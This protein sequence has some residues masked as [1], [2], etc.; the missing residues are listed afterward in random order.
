MELFCYFVELDCGE[1]TKEICEQLVLADPE[2]NISGNRPKDEQIINND[3]LVSGL[4][5]RSPDLFELLLILLAQQSR[6]YS[7]NI[8]YIESSVIL[9]KFMIF[10]KYKGIYVLLTY[11][12]TFREESIVLKFLC[13]Y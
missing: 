9:I 6:S 4:N 2:S 8:N 3:R 11:T 7:T 12:K 10:W 5:K 1:E 13:T